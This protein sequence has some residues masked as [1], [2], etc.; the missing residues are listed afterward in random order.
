MKHAVVTAVLTN[1]TLVHVDVMNAVE[2]VRV[3]ELGI[4]RLVQV[5]IK[6]RA[7]RVDLAAGR[8]ALVEI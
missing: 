6:L 7:E 3:A 8:L 4:D 2:T 1:V 5:P